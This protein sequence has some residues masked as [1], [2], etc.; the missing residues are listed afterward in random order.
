MRIEWEV[1]SYGYKASKSYKG[2]FHIQFDEFDNSWCLFLNKKPIGYY[3]TLEDAKEGAQENHDLNS[4]KIFTDKIK[5][6]YIFAK[7]QF[8]K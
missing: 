7:E 2:D 8:K 3:T 4:F 6:V 1:K 5:R